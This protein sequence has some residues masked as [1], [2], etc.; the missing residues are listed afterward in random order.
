MDKPPG[1]IGKKILERILELV[2]MGIR[3]IVHEGITGGKS[4]CGGLG[5][6]I[7]DRIFEKESSSKRFSIS[8]LDL[9][10]EFS[11]ELSA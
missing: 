10:K 4:S 2:P 5:V 9:L 11:L 3:E 1:G 7:P 8:F 6:L